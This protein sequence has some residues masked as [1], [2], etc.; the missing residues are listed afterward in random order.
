MYVITGATGNTGSRVAKHLLQHGH[1]VRVIGRNPDRLR[2]L[3]K[4]G[5]E[6]FVA[7]LKDV[8]A[9][10]KAFAG[11]EAVFAMIPPNLASRDYRA[12]QEWISDCI[13]AA[14]AETR[15]SCVVSLSSIGADKASGTGPVVGLHNL[16]QKLNA[17]PGLNAMHLRAGYFIE[18]TFAQADIIPQMGNCAGPLRP[19]LKL[20]M[21]HTRDIAQVAGQELVNLEFCGHQ[22]REVQGLR[23]YT[24][25]E[26][27]KIIGWAIGK[28]DLKY[29]QLPDDKLRPAMA[30]MGMSSN[31]A[32]LI[33]EM[34]AALN[35]GHMAALEPRS[36]HN[37]TTTSFETF[38]VGEFAPA[39]YS[40]NLQAA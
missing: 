22:T 30:Q 14:L 34:S 4:L 25:C 16:E 24:Y 38:A 8:T 11:A 20:P 18:N 3:V 5:A 27:A 15:V 10:T 31:F 40:A 12:E 21:V 32:D 6:P 29:I 7:D 19:D 2:S 35:S 36:A 9:L 37:T 39:Y 33:L 26:V 23:D 1:Q 13:A 28:P 17:I